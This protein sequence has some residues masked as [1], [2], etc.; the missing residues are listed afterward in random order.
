MVDLSSTDSRSASVPA[1]TVTY[2][3]AGEGTALVLLHGI[4]SS[5]RSFSSQIGALRGFRTIAWNAPGYGG[6]SRLPMAAPTAGDYAGVLVMLLDHLGVETC[7]VLG[8]SLGCLMAARFAADHPQRVLSLTLASIAAGHARLPA[9]E[10][11]RLLSGRLGDIEDLG[12]RGMA[13]KRGPRLLGP[14]AS[15]QHIRSVVETMAGVDSHGYAQA[16]RML[17]GGDIL[18]DLE[19]LPQQMPVQILFGTDDLITPPAANL[20]VAAAFPRAGAVEIDRAGHALYVEKPEAF[21]AALA[22]F[23]GGQDGR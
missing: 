3:E 23:I 2:L 15:P 17:S 7:H 8:H 18:A 4:G 13:E 21:N 1:G 10:R 14:D 22:A 11:A 12:P 16:A 19:R 6:S 9:E 20:R 5:A